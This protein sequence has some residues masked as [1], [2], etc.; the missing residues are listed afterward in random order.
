MQLSASC[1]SC[2]LPGMI[3]YPHS[4]DA[5]P[6]SDDVDLSSLDEASVQ[7][8]VPYVTMKN[9]DDICGG[10]KICAIGFFEDHLDTLRN[11]EFAAH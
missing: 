11:P 1:N 3:C 7:S 4:Q 2:M 10:H 9:I 6:K 5:K 8:L